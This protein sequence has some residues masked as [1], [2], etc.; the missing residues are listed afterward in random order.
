MSESLCMPAPNLSCFACCPPIR[1]AG[2]DHVQDK[3]SWRR[4]FSENRAAFLAGQLPDRVQIGF[5]CPGLGFLDASGSQVGCLL[6]P[7]RNG[8]RDLREPTGYRGKCARESCPQSRAYAA[9]PVDHR[10]ALI[11]LCRGM[12]PFTF[13]SR[14]LNPLMQLLAFGPEAASAAAGLGIS[15]LETL[16]AWTWL[17]ETDPAHGWLLARLLDERGPGLLTESGLASLLHDKA[18][19]LA[20]RLGPAPPLDQGEPLFS[21]CDEWE[22][23]FW[24]TLSGRHKARQAELEA[25][26][27]MAG[28]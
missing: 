23:R 14:A 24:R 13:S 19:E 27:N 22:A 5:S 7:A 9:M 6:H 3:G 4:M 10:A 25:W 20:K 16:S 17:Q 1:P 28:Y 26:R 8:G 2:Y 11:A 21:L 18:V 15:N 12:D